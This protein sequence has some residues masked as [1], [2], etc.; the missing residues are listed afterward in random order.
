MVFDK[1]FSN[2]SELYCLEPGLTL[3]LRILLKP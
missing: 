3:P 1:N 2:S